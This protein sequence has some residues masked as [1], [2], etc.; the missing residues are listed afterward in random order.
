M[1]IA[2]KVALITGGAAGIG[3]ATAERLKAEGAT[4]VIADIDEA[5]GKSTAEALGIQFVRLDVSDPDAWEEV[6]RSVVS[7]HGSLDIT[8]LN[9][10]ILTPRRG[11][12]GT[13]VGDVDI[14]AL[15]T[16]DYRRISAV[17]IDGVVFGTRAAV[18]AAAGRPASI[19]AT[20][21]IAGLYPFEPDPVYTMTKHAVIGFVRS[22]AP[23]LERQGIALNAVCPGIVLT[24]IAAR[25]D[26]EA[27]L[28]QGFDSLEPSDIANGV[29][30]AVRGGAS[31]RALA[32]VPNR[33]PYDVP[34]PRI[35]LG[36]PA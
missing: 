26:F 25:P 4:V 10:G 30:L 12:R 14:T 2:G 21:S 11:S 33:E 28:S 15:E 20:A 7:E 35:D 34:P 23:T 27:L 9:A 6:A 17:N 1:D 24:E 18:R 32:C 19:V 5:T 29:V 13:V 22:L 16:A 3:R 36:G 31:G 8:F